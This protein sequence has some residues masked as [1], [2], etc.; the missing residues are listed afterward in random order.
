MAADGDRWVLASPHRRDRRSPQSPG[1]LGD[2]L[3][4]TGAIDECV[5]GGG[6]GEAG[7][8]ALLSSGQPGRH[9]GPVARRG[10]VES[11]S[12]PVPPPL[13]PRRQRGRIDGRHGVSNAYGIAEP[14]PL[15]RADQG[16]TS[17]PPR[18]PRFS[19]LVHGYAKEKP[20]A[21]RDDH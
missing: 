16:T 21:C 6:V 1:E 5:A 7:D 18:H 12:P 17:Q 20:A 10:N 4:G 3:L 9:Q 19:E 8:T 14:L 11:R 13:I 15:N 2:A